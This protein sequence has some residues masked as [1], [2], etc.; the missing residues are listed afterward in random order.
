MNMKLNKLLPVCCA[1]VLGIGHAA[2]GDV[3]FT[4]VASFGGY[5]N[6][7]KASLTLDAAGNLFGTTYYGGDS[8]RGT[9]FELYGTSH[10][11]VTTL[12]T[13]DGV[14]TGTN[15]VAGLTF[16]HAGNLYGTSQL[17]GTNNRGTVFELSGA[18]HQT[19]T[20]LLNFN[21]TNGYYPSGSV[22]VDAAGNLFGTTQNGGASGQ[23]TAFELSGPNHQTLTTLATFTGPNGAQPVGG[24]TADAAGN[25]YG[26]TQYGGSDFGT[27]FELSGSNHQ[28]LT[29][30]W[31]FSGTD[32]YSP[33]GGVAAD[34]GGNL[35]GT[36]LA[37]GPRGQG[38]VFKLSGTSHQTLTTLLS[39]NG[40]NGG[41]P[42][43]ALLIDGAGKI[44]GTT[45]SGGTAGYGTV[46]EL[47]G[48]ND[49]TLTTLASF[50]TTNGANPTAGLT[51]DAF[52]NLYGTTDDAGPNGDGTAFE[53]AGSGFVPAAVPEPSGIAAVA[54]A[55]LFSIRRHRPKM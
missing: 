50:D 34:P 39:F 2:H 16:D 32:G 38:T 21:N 55:G 8:G 35:F 47:S 33:F 41:S 45:M 22:Y 7:P 42:E 17:G 1:G 11:T 48:T 49:Q 40:T 52:G 44:F 23:G 12:A 31:K 4:T 36:T 15:L 37:E 5:Y 18:N 43:G 46:Y 26:T 19:L 54:A 6:D 9:A 28:T 13:F 14:T 51:A 24:L 30:L 20:T 27:V 3:T 25:L 10:Q 29:T 53:I